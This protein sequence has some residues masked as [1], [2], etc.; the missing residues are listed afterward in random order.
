M[1]A[2]CR[3][4][5]CSVQP[6]HASDC[7][8]PKRIP[9]LSIDGIRSWRRPHAAGDGTGLPRCGHLCMVDLK[10]LRLHIRHVFL[11]CAQRPVER[12]AGTKKQIRNRQRWTDKPTFHPA[13]IYHKRLSCKAALRS[14]GG[15]IQT[16]GLHVWAGG[17]GITCLVKNRGS[18]PV[19]K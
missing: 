1:E 2:P 10:F 15:P 16:S 7:H 12:N 19:C 6:R 3:L 5:R 14:S 17:G 11:H 13:S 18:T 4:L 9:R 8:K